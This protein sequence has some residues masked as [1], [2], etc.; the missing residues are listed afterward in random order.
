MAISD[1][2]RPIE[3]AAG[4]YRFY[5][6]IIAAGVYHAGSF[7]DAECR[8]R[9]RQF[10]EK[11]SAVLKAANL[12]LSDIPQG[13]GENIDFLKLSTEQRL[14]EV[15]RLRDKFTIKK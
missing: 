14:P 15:N 13:I 8:K 10:S 6:K 7:A 12:T 1:I 3:K 5:W 11:M 4:N 2:Y 9:L